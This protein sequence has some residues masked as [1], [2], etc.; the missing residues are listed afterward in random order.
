MRNIDSTVY[1][2]KIPQ[3]NFVGFQSTDDLKYYNTKFNFFFLMLKKI[4]ICDTYLI[5]VDPELCTLC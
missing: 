1:V 3:F 4:H 2:T 5:S